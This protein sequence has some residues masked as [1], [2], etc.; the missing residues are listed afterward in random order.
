MKRYVT[1]AKEITV[2]HNGQFAYFWDVESY[3]VFSSVQRLNRIVS[4]FLN[5]ANVIR[6]VHE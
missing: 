2:S 4:S 3:R 6:H 1:S 5:I